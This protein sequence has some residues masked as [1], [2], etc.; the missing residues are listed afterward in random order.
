MK[1]VK[2]LIS[3]NETIGELM[4]VHLPNS[5]PYRRKVD[6]LPRRDL[7]KPHMTPP[8]IIT[9]GKVRSVLKALPNNK[10]PGSD[11]VPNEAL[12]SLPKTVIK[13][14]TVLYKVF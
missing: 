7:V 10:A 11:G 5:T 13:Y 4:N 3:P 2:S 9:E 1:N 8:E 14:I 6:K 12:K